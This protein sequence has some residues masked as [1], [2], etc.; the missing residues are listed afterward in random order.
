MHPAMPASSRTSPV[1]ALLAGHAAASAQAPEC[2][3]W[4]FAWLSFFVD[5]VTLFSPTFLLRPD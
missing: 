2:C 5:G 3:F 4:P 1:P